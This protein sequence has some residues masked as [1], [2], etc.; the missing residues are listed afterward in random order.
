MFFLYEVVLILIL[1]LLFLSYSKL[2]ISNKIKNLQ[3]QNVI[4]NNLIDTMDDGFYVLDAKKH[5]EKFS[6]N[7]LILLNTVFYSLN[8][9]VN[10]FEQSE[11]LIK[12]LLKQRK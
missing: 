4:I 3:H 12:I 2:K 1:V 11:D 5:I 10:F 6:P 7:L 9:F 8:E